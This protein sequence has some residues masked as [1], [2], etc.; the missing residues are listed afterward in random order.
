MGSILLGDE[1]YKDTEL[2]DYN[3]HL[4]HCQNLQKLTFSLHFLL[5][6]YY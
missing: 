3:E 5:D 1:W 4:K 6:R 2:G